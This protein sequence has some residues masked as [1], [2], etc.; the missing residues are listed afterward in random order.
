MKKNDQHFRNQ[1]E[2]QAKR[3]KKAEHEQATLLSQT[4]YI[5]TLGLLIIIPIIVGA[6]LGHWLDNM[7]EDYSAR[8]TVSLIFLGVVIGAL[9]A[10]LF[11]KQ[12]E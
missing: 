12:R 11:I 7:V 3:I 10:Y 1:I 6:Y 2:R 4:A 8:W 9:N 5:G